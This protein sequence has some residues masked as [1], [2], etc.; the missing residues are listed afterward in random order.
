[1]S[2]QSKPRAARGYRARTTVTHDGREYGA[3][4]QI[5]YAEWPD[6]PD[7]SR[8][9]LF[10]AAGRVWRLGPVPASPTELLV[11]RPAPD[12]SPTDFDVAGDHF[13]TG[14][15]R[16]YIVPSSHPGVL[17]AAPVPNDEARLRGYVRT[18]LVCPPEG[19]SDPNCGRVC[20]GG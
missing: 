4:E 11:A 14:A 18:G 9:D 17:E 10:R 7:L 20:E 15:R 13:S 8:G 5:P 6:V 12:D 16:W 3:G 19:C 2:A 1:M